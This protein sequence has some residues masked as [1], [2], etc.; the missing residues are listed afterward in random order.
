MY[1]APE[2][3]MEAKAERYTEA[4]DVWSYGMVLYFIYY[5]K[6]VNLQKNVYLLR[7]PYDPDVLK[8]IAPLMRVRAWRGVENVPNMPMRPLLGG[9]NVDTIIEQ[10]TRSIFYDFNISDVGNRIQETGAQ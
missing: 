1:S 9:N 7:N 3:Y 6:W 2:V 10:Y 4:A 8:K 5:E